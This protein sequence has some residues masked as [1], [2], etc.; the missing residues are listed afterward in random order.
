M[1]MIRVDIKLG[2]DFNELPM[3]IQ[4]RSSHILLIDREITM[5]RF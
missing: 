5:E 1:V 4:K 3:K 2:L